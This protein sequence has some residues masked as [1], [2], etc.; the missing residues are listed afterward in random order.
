MFLWLGNNLSPKWI[1]SVFGVNSVNEV[2]T[3]KNSIPVLDNP[4]N[5][6]VRDVISWVLNERRCSMRVRAIKKKKNFFS[7]TKNIAN[8]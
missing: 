8:F 6:R 7:N 3:D 1:Q 4:L 5:N 2:N